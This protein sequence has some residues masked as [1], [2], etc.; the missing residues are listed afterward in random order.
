VKQYAQIKND[1]F[2]FLHTK[3]DRAIFGLTGA[4]VVCQHELSVLL[5]LSA[6]A[7]LQR[8]V[9]VG[10]GDQRPAK[11]PG[12]QHPCAENSQPAVPL[13]PCQSPR[14]GEAKQTAGEP[15]ASS[16]AEI[17]VPTPVRP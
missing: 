8:P 4:V 3:T 15:A 17:A 7:G 10:R 16:S 6:R 2:S 11:R 14:T 5:R 1:I 13:L 12:L 9:R